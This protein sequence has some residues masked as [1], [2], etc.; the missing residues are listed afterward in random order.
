MIENPI[1]TVGKLKC[2]SMG[3]LKSFIFI[4]ILL[5]LSAYLSPASANP[6]VYWERVYEPVGPVFNGVT[7]SGNLFVAVADNGKIATSEDGDTWSEQASGTSAELRSV[8]YGNNIFVIVGFSVILTSDDGTQWFPQSI[9]GW[10]GFILFDIVYGN[11]LFVAVGGSGTAFTSPDGINW[12]PHATGDIS[13]K[14]AIT[15]GNGKFVAVGSSGK[16]ITSENGINW[17]I[18]DSKVSGNIYSVAFGN[19]RFVASESNYNIIYSDDGI[20]WEIGTQT[21]GMTDIVFSN[22]IFVGTTSGIIK[23]SLDGITFTTVSNQ[24]AV[25]SRVDSITFGIDFFVTA[26]K[27]DSSSR[28]IILKSDPYDISISGRVHTSIAGHSNLPVSNASVLLN[29]TAYST[30]TLADGSFQFEDIPDGT[31]QLVVNS[32]KFRDWQQ[33]VSVTSG[34]MQVLDITLHPEVVGVVVIPLF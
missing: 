19:N 2:T 11:G 13:E 4:G 23:Y 22:G 16:I 10:P 32:S 6:L 14:K 15:Y 33:S 29:G 12:T 17:T 24:L 26:G 1:I 5:I 31:Y 18:Q 3:N 27:D 8:A 21:Q 30:V 7:Y 9:P 28:G 20:T 25:G 34:N